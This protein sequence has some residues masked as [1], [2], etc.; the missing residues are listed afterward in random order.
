MA[1][2]PERAACVLVTAD[3]CANMVAVPGPY[4][5]FS[6]FSDE[7]TPNKETSQTHLE[8]QKPSRQLSASPISQT[9]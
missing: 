5:G 8:E 4:Q 2:P 6:A 7:P 1:E 3:L 9:T